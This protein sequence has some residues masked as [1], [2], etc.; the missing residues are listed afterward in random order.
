GERFGGTPASSRARRPA[1]R[2]GA[3]TWPTA[4]PSRR[5][6][7]VG[8]RA[9]ARLRRDRV[10]PQAKDGEA[11]ERED[12]AADEQEGR[13]LLR[14]VDDEDRGE[15]EPGGHQVDPHPPGQAAARV[16]LEDVQGAAG[17]TGVRDLPPEALQGSAGGLG[18][19]RALAPHPPP[20]PPPPEL[21]PPPPPPP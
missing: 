2:P 8:I 10:E 3:R 5:V 1:P 13:M 15:R 7:V 6:R 21:L 17:G 18:R 11:G 19:R 9:G 16:P 14:P 12:S 20:P 4:S